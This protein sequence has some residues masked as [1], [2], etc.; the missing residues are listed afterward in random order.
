[1][2]TPSPLHP[3]A[4]QVTHRKHEGGTYVPGAPFRFVMHT[5]EGVPSTRDGAISVARAHANPPHLWAWPEKDLLIQTVRLD[6]SAFALLHTEGTPATNKMGALQV[7]V[8]GFAK[9]MGSKPKTFW[10]WLGER[11]L[12]PL[13]GMGYAIDLGNV[14][15]TTGSD[16]Y[17]VR[18]SVRMSRAEWARFDGVCGHANVPDN[19]HWD[20]G[21]ARLDLVARYARPGMPVLPAPK[22]PIPTLKDDDEMILFYDTDAKAYHLVVGGVEVDLTVAEGYVIDSVNDNVVAV[23]VPHSAWLKIA[24]KVR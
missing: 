2:P 1:M 15:A 5:V 10:T 24:A 8:F 19:S 14:A 21:A 4:V 18:G 7:E 11:V 13:A 22:P 23:R 17:G 6:R 12:K 16:G 3:G 9:E 20:P